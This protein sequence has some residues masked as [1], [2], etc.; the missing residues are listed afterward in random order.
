MLH[1]MLHGDLSIHGYM[2]MLD[3]PFAK[4][5]SVA[6][7]VIGAVMIFLMHMKTSGVFVL[8]GIPLTFHF[9]PGIMEGMSGATGAIFHAAQCFPI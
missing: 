1:L 4:T 7:M 2:D 8:A 3:G 6:A 5:I 9:G